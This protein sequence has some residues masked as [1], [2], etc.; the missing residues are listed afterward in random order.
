MRA[1]GPGTRCDGPWGGY[2]GATSEAIRLL[3]K[4]YVRGVVA[5]F[6]FRGILLF[7]KFYFVNSLFSPWYAL[8]P[9]PFSSSLPLL[10][11]T[12]HALIMQQGCRESE[13][14]RFN[15]KLISGEAMV[16]AWFRSSLPPFGDSVAMGAAVPL[17]SFFCSS[18][19]ICFHFF[20]LHAFAGLDLMVLG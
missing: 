7:F 18:L 8:S 19:S 2:R 9:S 17:P 1:R 6:V 5:S 4:L 11:D 12:W 16:A 14:E 15:F 20:L 3:Q 13:R 10:I